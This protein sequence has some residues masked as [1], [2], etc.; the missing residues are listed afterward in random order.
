MQDISVDSRLFH[1]PDNWL[2]M[3]YDDTPYY[4]KH[5]KNSKGWKRGLKGIDLAAYDPSQRTLYLIESK[6]YRNHQRGK[7]ISPER[8]FFDKV[9][10]TFTGIVPTM[11][12]SCSASNGESKLQR[13][14]QDAKRLRLIYQF[15][16]PAKHSKMFP[17][18]FNLDEMQ[19][20]LRQEL[21]CFD[22]HVLVI[23][24]ATQTKVSWTAD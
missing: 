3:K 19:R 12:C 9:I 14:V 10:D 11:L 8:E 6:D 18:V 15:E 16:Q 13:S 4:Q 22:P 23:E 21:K 7:E 2:V 5:L 24:A 20:K 17:R 1:F